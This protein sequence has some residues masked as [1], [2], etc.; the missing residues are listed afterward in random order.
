[1]PRKYR[2]YQHFYRKNELERKQLYELF[3]VVK[4]LS[5]KIYDEH[6]RTLTN[7]RQTINFILNL[8]RQIGRNRQRARNNSR[9]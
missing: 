1:M 2:H 8:Q 3:D 5:Y 6:C 9:D 4:Q 7:K